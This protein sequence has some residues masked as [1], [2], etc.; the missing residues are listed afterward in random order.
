MS[1]L[2]KRIRN[3]LTKLR[4]DEKS[5]LLAKGETLDNKTIKKILKSSYVKD[6][7]L[8][9]LYNEFVKNGRKMSDFK[10]KKV[11]IN[12]PFTQEKSVTQRRDMLHI[13]DGLM[14]LIHDDVVDLNFFSKSAA[15]PKY[16]LVD[17]DLFMSKTYTYSMK[18]GSHLPSK[19]EKLFSKTESL[20]KYLKKE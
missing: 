6:K 9:N 18:K 10:D 12:T 11:I 5:V 14:Q 13:I 16:C 1:N 17:V 15:A 8:L 7:V 20:R 3:L 19:L 2:N 4:V